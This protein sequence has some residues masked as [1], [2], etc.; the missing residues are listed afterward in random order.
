MWARRGARRVRLDEPEQKRVGADALAAV[1]DR[2]LACEARDCRF[3]RRVARLARSRRDR[4]D[5]RHRDEG[6]AAGEHGADAVLEAPEDTVDVGLHE[7]VEVFRRLLGD[8]SVARCDLRGRGVVHHGVEGAE[9]AHHLVEQ[10]GDLGLDA[11]VA[12]E[13]RRLAARRL[14]LGHD[15]V[16]RPRLRPTTA[17]RAPLSRE[18][19]RRHLAD[20]A[21]RAGNDDGLAV[22]RHGVPWFMP[23]TSGHSTVGSRQTYGFGLIATKGNSRPNEAARAS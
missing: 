5:G 17:T 6:A 18:V 20:A 21:R 9:A 11:Q 16:P 7:V 14:D 12:G 8:G 19:Q 3:G 22:Q 23:A 15:L 13:Q 1:V 10:R 4:L 2:N